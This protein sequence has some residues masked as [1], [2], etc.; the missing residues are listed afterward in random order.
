[1]NLQFNIADVRIVET[2]FLLNPEFSFPEGKAISINSA[3]DIQYGISGEIANVVLKVSSNDGNQP[4]TY[5]VSLLGRFHF[6]EIPVKD[7]IDKI[8]HINCAAILF[9][10]IR[11][12]VADLTRRA[13]IPPFHLPPVNFVDVYNA[14]MASQQ[15]KSDAQEKVVRK[16]KNKPIPVAAT[17]KAKR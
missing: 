3:F 7:M 5:S 9:P 10:Y 16:H 13:G 4:F 2:H 17:P 14:R 8:V 12:S 1:M 6:K 11:E 15:A